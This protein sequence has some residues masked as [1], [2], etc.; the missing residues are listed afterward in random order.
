MAKKVIIWG[1]YTDYDKAYKWIQTELLKGSIEIDA[2]V[3]N[4]HNLFKR[5]DGIEVVPI[6]ELLVR[7]YDY[8]IN[9]NRLEPAM[10]TKMLELLRIPM[11]KVIPIKV[12][13]LPFFDLQ[14]YLAVR[15]S[16]V[17]IISCNCWGGYVY[18][19]LGMEFLSPFINMFTQ[20]EDYFRMLNHFDYYMVQPLRYIKD[21]YEVVLK[22]EYPIAGLGDV[23]LHFNHDTSFESA[24]EAWERRKVR[25]NFDNLFVEALIDTKEELEAFLE[26]P[27]KRKIGFTTI[28]CNEKN[29]VYVP[30]LEDSYMHNKYK[31]SVAQF[32]NLVVNSRSDELMQYD[33]LKLLNG[34]KDFMRADMEG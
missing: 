20:R 21:G 25:L 33:I 6:D 30:F 23:T 34:E 17:S 11:E 2:I 8:I 7:E 3:L 19:S 26:L 10:I 32:M 5:L 4:E 16:R 29:C 15:E 22:R 31:G 1:Q 18:D 14:R 12:F 24:E 9:L 28:K 13:E 27:F